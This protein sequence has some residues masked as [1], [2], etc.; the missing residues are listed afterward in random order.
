MGEQRF[1]VGDRVTNNDTTHVDVKEHWNKY[2]RR[3]QGDIID[4]ALVVASVSERA[5]GSNIGLSNKA[6]RSFFYMPAST[7]KSADPEPA[8]L[9]IDAIKELRAVA[10]LD[11]LSAKRAVEAF[12]QAA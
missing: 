7:L 11:L 3:S 12:E 6:G 8:T 10:G 2:F 9:K 1:K 4:G 5:T